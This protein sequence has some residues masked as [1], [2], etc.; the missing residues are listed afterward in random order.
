MIILVI[1]FNL[2]IIKELLSGWCWDLTEH[3]CSQLV[4]GQLKLLIG[5]KD[6]K[7]SERIFCEY[8]QKKS[9]NKV[10]STTIDYGEIILTTW[11]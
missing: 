2:E 7:P 3:Q 8:C 4:K 6:H 10:N 1:L 11:L 9:K 5:D